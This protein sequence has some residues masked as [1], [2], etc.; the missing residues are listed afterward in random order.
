MKL[1]DYVIQKLRDNGVRDVFLLAGGGIMHLLDSAAREDAINKY[2]TLHEQGAGFAA[3]GYAQCSNRLGVVF[4]TTGPGAT[5]VV[6]P[7]G[8]AFID[9]TPMLVLSGQV[10]T[11]DMT[12]IAGVRQ[13]GAQEIGILPIVESIT[14]YAVTVKDP[15]RIRYELE[16]AIHLATHGRPG[17]VWLDLPLDIQAAEVDPTALEG[18]T[19]LLE[20]TDALHD[21]QIDTIARI[22]Q[23][24]A[25]AERPAILIGSGVFLADALDD[26]RALAAE[27]RMPVL[28]SQRV[29]RAFRR[30]EDRYYFGN[31]GRIAPRYGNY[32]LQNCDFLLSIG[33]GLRYYLTVF[34]EERFAPHAKHAVVNIAQPEID[35][36]RM[37]VDYAVTMDA[38]EFIA[39]FRTIW[40]E[41]GRKACMTDKWLAYCDEMRAKYP[42]RNDVIP[43]DDGLSDGYLTTYAIEKYAKDDDIFL[44]SPSAFCYTYNMPLRGRQD[45]VCPMGL[46][47]MGTALPAAIGACT[48]AGGR[49]VI[50]GE[51]DGSL[52]HNIQ[53]LA[54]LHH[55]RLP[56]KLF[57]DTNLGYR[58]IYTMQQTHFGGNLAGCTVESGIEF[59]DLREIARA[60]HLDYYCIESAEMTDAVVARALADD[61]PAVI[62]VLSNL[63]TEFVPNIKSRMGADGKMQTSAL[64][65]MFPFLPEEEHRAN[66][67]ISEG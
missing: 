26:F 39:H 64:E 50:V 62:E 1:S 20:Q 3:D 17:P 34:N 7:L 37:P 44:A 6:T 24:L 40:R 21:E 65:D 15:K 58:Q 8:S 42:V 51:G 5:N 14:K 18:Y 38:K 53:E 31:V 46:G 27:L 23:G 66:M 32:T 35:K 67:A 30:G 4:A 47:S 36:L 52:Q 45:Y 16:K 54:L 60:Y 22:A 61:A 63:K 49:R 11:A 59:P 57:V 43:H 28:T 25:R 55:Y 56:I 41:S 33:C 10:K 12:T 19:P 9:S 2:Y 48:A 29:K 13:T